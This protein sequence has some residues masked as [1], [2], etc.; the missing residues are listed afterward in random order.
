VCIKRFLN[1]RERANTNESIHLQQVDRRYGLIQSGPA[2][3]ILHARKLPGIRNGK[4]LLARRATIPP[5]E[6][7][8]LRWVGR[9]AV[10]KI[11]YDQA[12]DRGKVAGIVMLMAVAPW[13]TPRWGCPPRRPGAGWMK[14]AD[15]RH[16]PG[17]TPFSG[18]KSCLL[19]LER[20]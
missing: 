15:N 18:W 11:D 6:K 16:R 1:D 12:S 14:I 17:L 7:G 9:G 4:D 20:S 13:T 10:T 8:G 3:V 19:N 5:A 2:Q